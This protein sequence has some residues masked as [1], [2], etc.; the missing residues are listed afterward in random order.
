MT[1]NKSP[2]NAAVDNYVINTN[3]GFRWRLIC[4]FD[5]LLGN[6]QSLVFLTRSLQIFK[7]VKPLRMPARVCLHQ[8]LHLYTCMCYTQT[9]THEYM[10]TQ[11]L[12]SSD[13]CFHRHQADSG[14]S[15]PDHA[16]CWCYSEACGNGG[17]DGRESMSAWLKLLQVSQ[18]LLP[19]L[20]SLLTTLMG[21]L[22]GWFLALSPWVRPMLSS[23]SL[24]HFTM[25]SSSIL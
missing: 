16:F 24:E 9:H 23:H 14:I 19:I 18:T 6:W 15:N 22:T 20:W 17:C 11:I 5:H 25:Q 21:I 7:G 8:R 3:R 2:R 10:H 13:V 4:S 1:F 12:E